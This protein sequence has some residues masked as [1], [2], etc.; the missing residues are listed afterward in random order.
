MLFSEMSWHL[1]CIISHHT[2]FAH[3]SVCVCAC[4]CLKGFYG[5]ACLKLRWLRLTD[6]DTSVAVSKEADAVNER[7][8]S[9]MR[10]CPS[11]CSDKENPP[12]SVF[13]TVGIR[14]DNQCSG[15]A[16]ANWSYCNDRKTMTLAMKINKWSL[17]GLLR[18]H[19]KGREEGA[20]TVRACVVVRVVSE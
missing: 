15:G 13:L 20:C 9:K 17:A 12:A 10:P 19:L 11:F 16:F 6:F 1:R 3:F 18:L 5:Q 4:V 14:K 2:R 7:L 8:S